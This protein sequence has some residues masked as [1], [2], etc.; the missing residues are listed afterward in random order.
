MLDHIIRLIAEAGLSRR[1]IVELA[2]AVLNG[3]GVKAK[4]GEMYGSKY[5]LAIYLTDTEEL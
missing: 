4:L 3:C 5:Y 2:V 1:E